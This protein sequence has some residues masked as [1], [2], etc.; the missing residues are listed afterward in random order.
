MPSIRFEFPI[1]EVWLSDEDF[2]G[3]D[4]EIFEYDYDYKL[5]QEEI[6]TCFCD[7]Y[8]VTKAAAS[9][10]ISDYDLWDELEERYEYDIEEALHEKLYDE[11]YEAWKG[12]ED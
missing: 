5:L 4:V 9:E 1:A 6:I 2:D 7:E 10:I 3:Y 11:A 12:G 8:K